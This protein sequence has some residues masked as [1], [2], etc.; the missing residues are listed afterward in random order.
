MFYACESF[1]DFGQVI[2]ICSG[3]YFP[4]FFIFPFFF[5]VPFFS[6]III[7]ILLLQRFSGTFCRE[8]CAHRIFQH[9]NFPFVY[10][11]SAR[12]KRAYTDIILEIYCFSLEVTFF[13]LKSSAIFVR[14]PI[15]RWRWPYLYLV[16]PK[17]LC[18][19]L[20]VLN[21]FSTILMS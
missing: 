8:N 16:N 21:Y 5:F 6:F 18:Y 7:I 12:Y 20:R 2:K 10:L 14:N 3:K 13:I 15:A 11:W 9:V 19:S 4:A 17:S 1:D